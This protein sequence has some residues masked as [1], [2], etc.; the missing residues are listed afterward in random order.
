MCRCRIFNIYRDA[1]PDK[2]ARIR[3]L[4]LNNPML[5]LGIKKFLLKTDLKL[6]VVSLELLPRK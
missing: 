5:G 2:R 4:L 1:V 6:E 3:Q